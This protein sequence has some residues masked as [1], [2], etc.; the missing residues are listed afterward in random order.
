MQI[1][2]SG[3]YRSGTYSQFVKNGVCLHRAVSHSCPFSIVTTGFSSLFVE[4]L[5]HLCT[6]QCEISPLVVYITI[7][8]RYL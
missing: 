5:H 7:H 1:C 3:C 4:L 2:R 6:W 8:V